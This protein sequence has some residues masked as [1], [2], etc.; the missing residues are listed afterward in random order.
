MMIVVFDDF[1]NIFDGF[2]CT[3]NNCFITAY[4]SCSEILAWVWD[5]IRNDGKL[6]A[7]GCSLVER[8]S[9]D[10]ANLVCNDDGEDNGNKN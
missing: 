7:S 5:L 2:H 4:I 10:K 3:Q 8:S 9:E 1:V 6:L